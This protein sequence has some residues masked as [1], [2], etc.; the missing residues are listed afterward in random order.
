M[1]T[2]NNQRKI[3]KF[4]NTILTL[5]IDYQDL[6]WAYFILDRIHNKFKILQDLLIIQIEK[7]IPIKKLISSKEA[8]L[9]K[10]ATHFSINL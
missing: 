1:G 2:I 3:R 7:I 4:N 5:H 8:Y 10:A 6:D 9:T